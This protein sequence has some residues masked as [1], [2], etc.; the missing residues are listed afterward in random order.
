MTAIPQFAES[1]SAANAF[2]S[3]IHVLAGID[4]RFGGPTYSVPRLS[5]ALREA[6]VA[7][8]LISTY[9]ADAAP[10]QFPHIHAYL[11]DFS[12]VPFLRGLRL[13]KGLRKAV[14]AVAEAAPSLSV[15]HSHGLWL[16]PN[17]WAGLAAA[18]YD[19]ALIVSPRGMLAPAA[20]A[21]SSR[22]KRF[23]W[24]L[25]QRR[26]YQSA[27]CYHATSEQ[28]AHDIREFG[29]TAPIAVI[30]N[31]VDLPE[32][33]A[34]AP[35][36]AAHPKT[37][38]ALGRIHPIKGLDTLIR[39]WTK[40]APARPDWQLVI[41]GPDDAGYG[42]TLHALIAEL[43]CPRV[44]IRG[45]AYDGDKWATLQSAQL[46]VSV[47]Q[48]E[49]FGLSI[50]E[51]LGSGVPAIVSKGAPWAGMQAQRCGWW[52]DHGVEPLVA[53]LTEAT[54][55]EAAQLH[56]MGD[57]AQRW[58]E[59]DFSWRSRAQDMQALYAWVLDQADAPLFLH[60]G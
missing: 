54:A 59:R 4:P 3:A 44:E 23:F 60:R 12:R 31:G 57:I 18:K 9:S 27:A 46:F 47:S 49:N 17:V 55:L 24:Q 52:I 38:L 16:L 14:I 25:L 13:S 37:I 29:I 7:S 39:A 34:Q 33:Q 19:R 35:L 22:K 41:C 28:E 45:A 26:A 53:A 50:A 20:L 43:S 5:A 58:I 21:Y 2:I 6:G 1:S 10:I 40:L 32:F 56:A 48:S 11:H 51:A 36:P 8:T 15:L 42:Q 30:G